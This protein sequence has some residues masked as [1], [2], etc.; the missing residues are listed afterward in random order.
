MLRIIKALAFSGPVAGAL[1]LTK[2]NWDN[3]VGDKAVF[4]NIRA[5][6]QCKECEEVKPNWDKLEEKFKDHDSLVVADVDCSGDGLELCQELRLLRVPAFKYGEKGDLVDYLGSRDFESLEKFAKDLKPHCNMTK[7]HPCDDG[8]KI[9]IERMQKLTKK[10]R[11]AEIAE[12]KKEVDRL[13]AVFNTTVEEKEK[14][15]KDFAQERDAQIQV[16]KDTGLAM[17]KAVHSHEA[18]KKEKGEL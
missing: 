12:L 8:Q 7:M 2:E 14:K 9:E 15:I 6:F 16:V 5:G 1:Q 11:E 10:E 4:L 13:E 18:D 3:A 17:M